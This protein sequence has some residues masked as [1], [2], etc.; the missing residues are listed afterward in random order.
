MTTPENDAET[1]TAKL[2]RKKHPAE[3]FLRETRAERD[4]LSGN[5]T[6]CTIGGRFI[7][8]NTPITTLTI[9][10]PVATLKWLEDYSAPRRDTPESVVFN[11]LMN[12]I[13]EIQK[14]EK[15]T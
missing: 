2:P 6:P 14:S 4:M 9:E 12:A 15:G 5:K 3:D 7:G 8:F 11:I 1:I 10:I 13:E